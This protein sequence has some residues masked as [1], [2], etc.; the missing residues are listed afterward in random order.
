MKERT[1]NLNIPLLRHTHVERMKNRDAV[2]WKTLSMWID[3][4][5]EGRNEDEQRRW[6]GESEFVLLSNK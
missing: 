2:L 1:I 6:I 3:K 5:K 4:I